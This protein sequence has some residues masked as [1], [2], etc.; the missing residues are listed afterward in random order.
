MKFVL[1]MILFHLDSPVIQEFSTFEK[2]EAAR[3]HIQ[4]SI[5]R[6]SIPDS[7]KTQGCYQL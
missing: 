3:V 7:I 4:K 1:I 6:S 2:C 5:A